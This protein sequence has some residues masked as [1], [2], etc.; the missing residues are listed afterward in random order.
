MVSGTNNNNDKYIN[1]F[2]LAEY[3]TI[4]AAHHNTNNIVTAFF[5]YYILV[6]SIPFP[7]F[8]Y[9]TQNPDTFE[10]INSQMPWIVPFGSIFVCLIGFCFMCYIINLR[11]DAILY[12]R[13]VNGIRNHYYNQWSLPVEKEIKFRVLP[14][15]IGLPDYLEIFYFWPVITV[16]ALLDSTYLF[17]GIFYHYKTLCS[18]ILFSSLSIIIHGAAYYLSAKYRNKSY[19]AGIPKEN[20]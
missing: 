6:I 17:T 10:K 1:D 20:C 16:F 5:K 18:S 15:S 13:T 4:A 7:L 9:L 3:N 19:K 12:A 14:K 2:L 8:G 11:M